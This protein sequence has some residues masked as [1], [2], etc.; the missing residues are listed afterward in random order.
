MN[1]QLAALQKEQ[2][3][4]HF[5]LLAA[6]EKQNNCTK[7]LTNA[8]LDGFKTLTYSIQQLNQHNPIPGFY[9][10]QHNAYYTPQ[11]SNTKYVYPNNLRLT[12]NNNW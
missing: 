12:G 3:D 5:S 7:D 10:P 11:Q 9:T 6:I 2:D 1:A 8:I 4:K